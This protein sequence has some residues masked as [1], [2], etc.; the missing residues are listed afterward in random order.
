VHVA[1]NTAGTRPYTANQYGASVSVV[2]IAGGSLIGTIPLSDGGFN[3][4]VAPD[5]TRLYVTTAS[6]TLHVIDTGSN[7]VLT[8]IPVGA[9]ANGLA[10]DADAD[11]LYVSSRD[12]NTV[13]AIDAASNTVLR[14]YAVSGMPQRLA[15]APGGATLY[16]AN[17]TVG[18]DE[19]DPATGGRVSVPAVSPGAVGLA[20]SPDGVQLFVANPPAGRLTVVDVATRTMVHEVTMCRPRNAVVTVDGSTAVV[21]DET[22]FVA[23]IRWIPRLR[24]LLVGRDS[25]GSE[26]RSGS[27]RGRPRPLPATDRGHP[28]ACAGTRP[29][30]SR[31]RRWLFS[32][33]L[34]RR[35]PL[36]RGPG[37][38]SM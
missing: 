26:S 6:G 9:A 7:Q 18:L 33:R 14:T 34:P 35:T 11:V 25:L 1:I 32:I 2:D 20:I 19:L 38:C 4:L 13:T 22:R 12:A 30:E 17:E 29:G 5:G 24:Q 23:F 15:L 31:Q 8:T 36:G 10:F 28:A 21:T 27:V 3:L 37:A 16:V